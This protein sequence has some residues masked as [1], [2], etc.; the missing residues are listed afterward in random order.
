[1][2][3]LESLLYEEDQDVR[4]NV[5][6]YVLG[7]GGREFS[8][9]HFEEIVDELKDTQEAGEIQGKDVRWKGYRE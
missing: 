3:E 9:V 8:H 5:L 4:P 7:L 6:G 2:S 1:M